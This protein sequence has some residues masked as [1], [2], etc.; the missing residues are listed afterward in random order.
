MPSD[1]ERHLILN[2]NRLTTYAE[3]KAEIELVL[4]SALGSKSATQRPGAG[5]SSSGP[6]P[7]D[8]DAFTSW[9]ASVVKRFGSKSKGKPKGKS[10]KGQGKGKPQ[11]AQKGKGPGSKDIT[12]YN[13]GKAGHKASEC[14][15]KP[16]GKGKDKGKSGPKGQ[17]GVK[18]GKAV[19]GLEDTRKKADAQPE[20]EVGVLDLGGMSTAKPEQWM[21]FNLDTGAAR[22]AVPSKWTDRM[23]V[24]EVLVP[25]TSVGVFEGLNESGKMCRLQG[26][27]A[28]VHTPLASA[29]KCLGHGR[30]DPGCRRWADSP[31]QF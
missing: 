30:I 4:E 14:W 3:M 16:K 27:M 6:A 26:S 18:G 31:S 24:V 17:K 19:A 15:S 12:C 9:I 8:V 10:D 2:K 13:C 5:V 7:M 22:T 1:I 25:S 23:K 11:Q 28:E 21:Q 20:E 29:Y